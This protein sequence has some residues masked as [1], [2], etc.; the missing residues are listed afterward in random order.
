MLLP[1]YSEKST[2]Y[3]IVYRK[4]YRG[5]AENVNK[6]EWDILTSVKKQNSL[7]DIIQT[8]GISCEKYLPQ[9]ISKGWI[10]NFKENIEDD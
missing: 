3:I 1:D 2:T 5:E 10:C 9:F 7:A 4:K 8:H 6:D